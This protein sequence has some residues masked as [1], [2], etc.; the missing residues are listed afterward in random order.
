MVPAAL[1]AVVFANGNSDF[2]LGTFKV[3]TRHFFVGNVLW[4]TLFHT[5][6][7]SEQLTKETMSVPGTFTGGSP[8]TVNKLTH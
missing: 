2:I 8:V 6:S 1:V 4:S 3:I 7:M 5:F